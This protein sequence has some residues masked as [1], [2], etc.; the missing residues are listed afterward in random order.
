M[1]KFLI[2]NPDPKALDKVLQKANT[3]NQKNGPFDAIILLGDV[4]PPV[5][6]ELPK[7]KLEVPTYF[8][9]GSSSF[10]D[11]V[12]EHSNEREPFAEIIPN[13][14][15]STDC[16]SFLKLQTGIT[17]CI[18]NGQYES[19]DSEIVASLKKRD[20]V[21]CDI[22]VTYNWPNAIADHQQRLGLGSSKVDEIVKLIR[23]RYHFCVGDNDGEFLELQP[24]V[25]E[26]SS[27]TRFISLGQEGSGKKWFY[28]FNLSP[29][30]TSIEPL[31]IIEN[32]FFDKPQLE[33]QG[34]LKPIS[35]K[36]QLEP[37]EKTE[38]KKRK[39]VTPDQCYFCLSNPKVETHM[40]ISIG[41]NCYMTVAKGPL[42]KSSN[43][44]P[45]SGHA[46]I[47]PI[48][49]TPSLK[50][51]TGP[52][53]TIEDNKVYQ[54]MIKYETSLVEAFKDKYP[55]YRLIFFEISRLDNIHHC[56]QFLPVPESI[57]SRF[58]QVL[59][60]KSRINN[61][62]YTKNESLEFKEF[63]STEDEAYSK[64]IN[65]SDYLLFKVYYN[66]NA[67]I[68]KRIYIAPLSSQGESTVDLQFPRRVLA[69]L[70]L[71][72]NRVYWEKCRQPVYRET[73]ECEKFKEFFHPFDFTM[74]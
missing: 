47:I 39:I 3:Q 68:N 8:T 25:W 28:A 12:T 34:E 22:L 23:P 49:H 33:L 9:S 74:S 38:T 1:A 24:F 15:A 53:S 11:I 62:T 40:I 36:R 21:D 63:E 54:E 50:Q 69:Y 44:L 2:L 72:P 17:I 43:K 71:K 48:D 60:E 61:E 19:E 6:E 66:E 13:L 27:Y 29:E 20:T 45:F 41:G 65:E 26:D 52:D 35:T 51:L 64:I 5:I 10:S 56:V 37:K 30:V 67:T 57:I 32:P 46:L 73:H 42:T 59:E 14:I 18:V 58:S 16:Y 55:N 31:Q 70:L 4:I 7:T